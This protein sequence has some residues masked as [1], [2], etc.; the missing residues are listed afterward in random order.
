MEFDIGTKQYKVIRG[1]KPT[2]FEIFLNGELLNQDAAARDYQK[3][4]EE[5]VLKL[6]YKSF[7]Q[8]V[9]LGSASFTPF[10]QLPAAHRREVIEDLLDIKI[11]SVMN[12]VLKIKYNEIRT[13]V[14]EIENKIEVGKQKVKIQQDYIKTLEGDRQKKVNDVQKRISETNAEIAK[15][16]LDCKHEE[17][18]V[19]SL[20]SFIVD[21]DERRTKQQE[22]GALVKKL[23]SRI[24][25]QEEHIHFYQENDVCPTCSQNLDEGLKQSAVS[26]HTTKIN[27]IEKAI[28]QISDQIQTI[29]V[30]LDEIAGIETKI[31]EHKSTIIRINSSIIAAQ[32]YMQKLNTE[33]LTESTQ[34]GNIDE[35]KIKLKTLAKEIVGLSGQKSGFVEE[36]HYLDVS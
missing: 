2:I 12:E 25:T 32:Q 13:K 33:L 21:A 3:Y 4:L 1:I 34:Q 28:E 5:H 11:F 26:S 36:K 19:S 7:T 16:S 6:N 31:S 22:L 14:V 17:Q 15:L 23:T 30:R 10:M 27:E 20:Q 24:K 18:E 8:I 29:E 35:E 9:I